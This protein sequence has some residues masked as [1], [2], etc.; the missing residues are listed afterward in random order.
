MA[1]IRI[2]KGTATIIP[3]TP[4]AL[5]PANRSIKEGKDADFA[6]IDKDFNVYMTVCEG[7]VVFEK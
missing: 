5:Y 7:N 6:V 2:P 1:E 4:A 3:I